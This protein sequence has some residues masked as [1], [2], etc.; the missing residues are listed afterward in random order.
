MQDKPTKYNLIVNKDEQTWPEQFITGKQILQLAG[1][2]LDWVVNQ[3]VPGPGEDPE[4]GLDQKVDLDHQAPPPGTKRFQTRK[5][6]TN[7][8][9]V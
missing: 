4:I 5:P 7:P 8:G 6:K 1:S 3:L 2:P 9:Q